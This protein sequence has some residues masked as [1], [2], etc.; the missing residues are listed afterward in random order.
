MEKI[1]GADNYDFFKTLFKTLDKDG[2]GSLERGELQLA[3]KHTASRP[4]KIDFYLT[5][6]DDDGNGSLNLNEFMFLIVIS[7]CNFEDV[8]ASCRIFDKFD[9]NKNGKLE[10]SELKLCLDEIGLTFDGQGDDG[11]LQD[12]K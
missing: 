1:V 11:G 5:L 3:L 12:S 7:Q 10:I 2:S 9:L 6:G 4:D 8:E